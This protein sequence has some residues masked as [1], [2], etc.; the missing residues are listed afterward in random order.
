NTFSGGST[1]NGGRLVLASSQA[2]GSGD[3]SVLSGNIGYGNAVTI[4]NTVFLHNNLTLDVATGAATQEGALASNGG[5]FA[6]TKTGAG[7]LTLFG[8]NTYTGGTTVAA[9]ILRIGT[10]A[11]GAGVMA[12][13]GDGAFGVDST[14]ALTNNISIGNGVSGTLGAAPGQ[15]LTLNG[16]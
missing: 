6:I 16:A 10:G 4:A 11:L 12:F 2:L 15:T 8:A 13:T 9:G 1:L 3:L 5:S 14:R 7:T